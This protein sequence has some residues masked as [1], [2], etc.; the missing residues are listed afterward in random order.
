MWISNLRRESTSLNGL[1]KLELTRHDTTKTTKT[2]TRQ[3]IVPIEIASLTMIG[4]IGVYAVIEVQFSES[5]ATNY[6]FSG[7]QE[8]LKKARSRF[9]EDGKQRTRT[10]KVFA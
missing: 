3:R 4:R 10:L 6:I 5:R 9:P 7:A 8:K 1:E 2:R